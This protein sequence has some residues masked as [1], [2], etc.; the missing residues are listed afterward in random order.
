MGVFLFINEKYKTHSL[1][2]NFF[3]EAFISEAG[4]A[5]FSASTDDRNNF[6]LLLFVKNAPN[7]GPAQ[8]FIYHNANETCHVFLF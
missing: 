5:F 3:C 6:F 7:L 8:T 4:N 1:G 2:S